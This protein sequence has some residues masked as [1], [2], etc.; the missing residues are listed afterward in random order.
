MSGVDLGDGIE[1]VQGANHVVRLGV[2]GVL[3]VNHGVRGGSLLGVV[4]DRVGF[5]V[6]DHLVGEVRVAQITDKDADLLARDLSPD[7][8]SGLQ[9]L[10]GHQAV[11][12]HLV[13]ITAPREVVRRRNHV[14]GRRQVQSG[15]PAQV[16]VA[17][18]NE[19]LHET[20]RVSLSCRSRCN[21]GGFARSRQPAHVL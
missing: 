19:D 4:H 8:H 16:A 17:A 13:V 5:E 9:A 12:T 6:G 3:A 15:A 1:H 11:D 18:Q 7:S 21:H 10:D 2:H 14:T 20:S